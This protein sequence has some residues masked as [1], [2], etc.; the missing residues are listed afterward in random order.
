MTDALI[1]FV[2]NL[3]PGKVKTRIGSVAGHAFALYVYQKLLQHTYTITYY[4]PVAK[5]VF[6][7]DAIHANDLWD[8]QHYY[9]S[10]QQGPDLG[11]R[12]RNA[13]AEVFAKGYQKVCIIG[14]DCYELTSQTI[15][16]AF[17]QLNDT[18]LVLGPASDGGYYLLGMRNSLKEVFDNIAWSTA[19]VLQQTIER[20]DA[21]YSYSFLPTLTDVDTLED[22]PEAWRQTQ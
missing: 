2:R 7:T 4:L 8:T 15:E 14:S 11:T 10:L 12:I 16:K 3:E 6:Y 9:K 1:L 13:F 18:D 20:I 5:F 19:H 22:V 17:T 21:A